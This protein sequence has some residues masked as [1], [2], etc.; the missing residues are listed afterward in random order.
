MTDTQRVRLYNQRGSTRPPTGN[1]LWHYNR[2]RRPGGIRRKEQGVPENTTIGP[3]TTSEMGEEP[4]GSSPITHCAP[5]IHNVT[6]SSHA[7]YRQ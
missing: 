4:W 5:N 7:E 6:I 3:S 2:H 1:T